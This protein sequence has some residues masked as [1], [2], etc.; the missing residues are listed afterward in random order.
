MDGEENMI[1]L[2]NAATTQV[3][4]EVTKAM[5][6]YFHEKYG[7]PSSLYEIGVENKEAIN[8]ARADIAGT[9]GAKEQEIYFTSGGTESDNW[10]LRNAAENYRDKGK[11]IITSTI[12]H[13]AIT[14][15]CEYLEKKGFEISYINVDECGMIKINELKNA[16]RKDTIL[17]SVMFA[18]NEV[19]TV[20]PVEEIGRIA[21]QAGVLFHTD[22]VQAYCHVPIAVNELG[23]DMLSASG[24][25]I[26]GPKGVG[27]LYV[28]EG[29]RLSPMI[30]GGAQEHKMRAGTENVPGIVGMAEAA[31]LSHKFM[32]ANMEKERRMRDY[33]VNR[34]MREI[35]FV[36]FNGSKTS[37]LPGNASFS[38][39]YVDGQTLVVMLDMEG[40]CASSGS[41]CTSGSQ[42]PSH[43]LSAMGM[44]ENI[45]LGTLRLTVGA[46]TT[47]EEADKTVNAIKKIVAELRS[48]SAE[49][50]MLVRRN[51][52]R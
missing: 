46:D 51:Y 15:T 9:L 49:Y 37:R 10:A 44:P 12:E 11:H 8:K 17:I 23:I 52:W 7:N 42:A 4:P 25:K 33:L 6:P 2:D 41:A 3:K 22:A 28:R 29:I 18:N 35:P 50:Q 21:K 30:F 45:A 27:F 31:M 5:M 16:I 19:G 43:V 1:Y 38:F 20:E 26:C 14:H 24:H 40:V 48:K 47:R 36:H 39:R 32:A 13:H 34:I